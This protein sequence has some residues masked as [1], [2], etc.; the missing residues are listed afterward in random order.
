MTKE[1]VKSV[2]NTFMVP[3]LYKMIRSVYLP[4]YRRHN[5]YPSIAAAENDLLENNLKFLRAVL[6]GFPSTEWISSHY[7]DDPDAMMSA[8]NTFTHK[9]QQTLRPRNWN[10][11]LDKISIVLYEEVFSAIAELSLSHAIPQS[12]A[13]TLV[14]NHALMTA[15]SVPSVYRSLKTIEDRLIKLLDETK[16]IVNNLDVIIQMPAH[17]R[18]A[19]ELQPDHIY[20]ADGIAAIMLGLGLLYAN[21]TTHARHQKIERVISKL[22]EEGYLRP[23]ENR[24]NEYMCVKKLDPSEFK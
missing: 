20:R 16:A 12:Y 21:E 17:L 4:R 1:L 13:Y 14:A 7:E 5:N 6:K 23:V 22:V 9:V 18:V 11:P 2:R 15:V 3:Q 8:L 10:F 19:L 24:S